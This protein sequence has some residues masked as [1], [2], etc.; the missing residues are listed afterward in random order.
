MLLFSSKRKRQL[1]LS[2]SQQSDLVHN[3]RINKFSPHLC[4]QFRNNRQPGGPITTI[5]DSIE[6][7]KRK[8]TMKGPYFLSSR[9]Q[10]WMIR[11]C[12]LLKQ[13]R[14]FSFTSVREPIVLTSY[15]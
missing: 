14:R 4:L 10:V 3:E 6:F 5:F 8:K 15:T 13:V 9:I 2:S 1:L 12:P 7:M 11:L